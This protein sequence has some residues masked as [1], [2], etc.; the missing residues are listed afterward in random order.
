MCVCACVCVNVCVCEGDR[1]KV[2]V[3]KVVVYNIIYKRTINS[4]HSRPF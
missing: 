1:V 4:E 3:G 2:S